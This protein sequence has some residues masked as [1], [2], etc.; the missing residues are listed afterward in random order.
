MLV[1]EFDR[2][3]E[4]AVGATPGGVFLLTG[5]EPYQIMRLESA[6]EAAARARGLELARVPGDEAAPG[7]IRRLA[8]EGSLFS[9]GRL[10]IVRN[11][12]SIPVKVQ[13]ELLDAVSIPASDHI[14]LFQTERTTLNTA[15]L[16]KLGALSVVYASWEPF[17]GRMW[18]W[19]KRL[20]GEL[21]IR[22]DRQAGELVEA[23]AYGRLFNL[24]GLMERISVR[25]GSGKPVNSEMVLALSGGIPEC[26]AL[27]MSQDA[28][29]GQRAQALAKLSLLL[30]SGEEPIRLL[31]LIHSQWVLAASAACLVNR[32]KSESALAAALGISP[33]R[34]KWV[35]EASRF[36]R[37]R[38]L[39]PVAEAFSETDLRL[40][41]SWDGVA[42]LAPFIAA[43]TLPE[44]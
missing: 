11:V 33:Y 20:S 41:R 34:A 3:L 22:L 8:S 30:A 29:T 25:Y 1:K 42:A 7:D 21:G 14:F 24:W 16:K 37:A 4:L 2:A 18:P 23:L 28:V 6:I 36:W 35:I 19:T 12:E 31:A 27:D 32:G 44:E 5:E 10:I 15:F 17:A 38:A 26:T 43:L 40:K 13:G 39:G 9:S